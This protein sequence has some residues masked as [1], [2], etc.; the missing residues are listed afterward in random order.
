MIYL[1]NGATTLPKA[2]GVARAMAWA[3]EHCGN[4]GRS[5]HRPAMDAAE[6]VYSCREKAAKRFG[7]QPE[8]AIFTP[9]CTWGLNAAIQT[10]VPPG[11]RAVISGFEHNAV[12]RPLHA[13]GARV[14]VAGRRLFDPADTL[15]AFDRALGRGADCAVFTHGSN[16]F[17]YR[18]PVE[19]LARLCKS[20]GVPF[21]VDAAQTAGVLP[22]SLEKLGADFIALPGHKGLRGPQGV[23][24]LLCTAM[25][26]PLVRG[27][28]GGDSRSRE[29]PGYLPDAMEAGTLPVPLIAGLEAAL[30]ALG[31]LGPAARREAQ[32]AGLC[33]RGLKKLGF[34]VF[35]GHDQLGTVSF[36]GSADCE[37]IARALSR[38]G[39][40]VRAGLHCAPL[41]HESAGTQERGTVRVSFGP[42]AGAG[43]VDGLLRALKDAEVM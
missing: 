14:Q 21:I 33:A 42:N 11:G 6:L 8:Q 41:A 26:K 38:R 28:T 1:D 35:S 34:R 30:D 25:P 24:L 17:G 23:G 16:V 13:L 12:V 3:V 22:L 39:V 5:G 36:Q 19:E 2:P 10:L 7:C 4:P 20:R 18:L 37:E 27:G 29:M 40:A 9:G 32:A 43:Q 31:E 15:E